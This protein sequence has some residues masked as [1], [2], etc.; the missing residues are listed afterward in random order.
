MMTSGQEQAI[1]EYIL[2]HGKVYKPA[3]LPAGI[4]RGPVKECYDTCV[5]QVL[6]HPEYKYVE[7]LA[8]HPK[9]KEEWIMH[10]WITDGEHAFDPT[11][12]AENDY[13]KEIPIP[14]AYI[15]IEM[16]II[17]VARFMRSTQYHGIFA[18]SFRDPGKARDI[19]KDIPILNLWI[20]KSS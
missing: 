16:D 18:N 9:D 19:I 5:I 10:A 13:G 2:E 11:W 20:P 14:T 17:K 1:A 15:G 3:L 8:R 6:K 12:Y 4:K 7:G